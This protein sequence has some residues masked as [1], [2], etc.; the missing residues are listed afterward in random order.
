MREVISNVGN[1][2][3]RTN[4]KLNTKILRHNQVEKAIKYKYYK[5]ES[6]SLIFHRG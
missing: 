2:L 6:N 5:Q 4:A 1:S 3:P